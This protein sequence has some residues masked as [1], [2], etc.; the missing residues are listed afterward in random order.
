MKD[1]D[2]GRTGERRAERMMGRQAEDGD[3]RKCSLDVFTCL[4]HRYPEYTKQEQRGSSRKSLTEGG[5]H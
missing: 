5:C 3:G 4:L 1:R 2:G